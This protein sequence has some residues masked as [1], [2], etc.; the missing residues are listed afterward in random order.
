MLR[1][2]VQLA[3]QNLRIPH[4][5]CAGM[6]LAP[7]KRKARLRGLFGNWRASRFRITN[8]LRLYSTVFGGNKGFERD[9]SY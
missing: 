1:A 4:A 6:S 5:T 9:N 8:S 7:P 2:A 3:N